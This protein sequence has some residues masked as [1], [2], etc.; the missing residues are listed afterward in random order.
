MFP[1]NTLHKNIK[2]SNKSVLV[3]VA[4]ISRIV[5]RDCSV[6]TREVT[7]LI[8]TIVFVSPSVVK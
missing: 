6:R 7:H 4:G 2:D 5:M 8:V 1:K 3:A